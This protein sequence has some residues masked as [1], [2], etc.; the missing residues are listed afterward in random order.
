MIP[1]D[2][3]VTLDG[4]AEIQR[5]LDLD[6]ESTY[7][8]DSGSVYLSVAP[9]WIWTDNHSTAKV[10]TGRYWVRL[11]RWQRKALSATVT[12]EAYEKRYGIEVPQ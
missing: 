12:R 2:I 1:R 5:V 4:L 10:P 3:L 7:L 11:K 9:E 8:L 6:N